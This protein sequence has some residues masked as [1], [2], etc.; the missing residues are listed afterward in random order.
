MKFKA[1]VLDTWNMTVTSAPGVL[2]LKK[3]ADYFCGDKK[4]RNIEL[5]GRPYI[6]IRIKRIED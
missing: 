1:E 3:N 6:A 2:T 4:G 5:P